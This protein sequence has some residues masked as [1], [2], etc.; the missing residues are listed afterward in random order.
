MLPLIGTL[1]TSDEAFLRTDLRDD[2]ERNVSRGSR[3]VLMKPLSEA[4]DGNDSEMEGEMEGELLNIIEKYPEPD[5]IDA[6][7]SFL[8]DQV[9]LKVLGQRKGRFNARAH[10]KAGGFSDAT[11]ME[12]LRKLKGN[13]E[14]FRKCKT[15]AK[16]IDII[17]SIGSFTKGTLRSNHVAMQL[18]HVVEKW[19][20]VSDL[21]MKSPALEKGEL[22][23]GTQRWK[24]FDTNVSLIVNELLD[25]E[26]VD[27][28]SSMKDELRVLGFFGEEARV[29]EVPRFVTRFAAELGKSFFTYLPKEFRMPPKK[30]PFG[31]TPAL[32]PIDKKERRELEWWLHKA[33]RL[34]RELSNSSQLYTKESRF[35]LSHASDANKA[36]AI[37]NRLLIGLLSRPS[38]RRVTSLFLQ[39]NKHA[40]Q[41]LKHNGPLSS[42]DAARYERIFSIGY[43]LLYLDVW[44][45]N[46]QEF[47]TPNKTQAKLPKAP[48]RKPSTGKARQS[49]GKRK[50]S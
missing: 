22:L 19:R 17:D 10:N 27:L 6:F 30:A 13:G 23:L 25:V 33:E 41:F 11:W 36:M 15:L 39:S 43:L 47:L 4:F 37:L 26:L 7:L 20:N 14:Q 31:S 18:P 16:A 32:R 8:Q 21:H 50:R 29:C 38:Y 1:G 28:P 5:A 40:K 48:K 24:A 45:R 12:A 46:S 9:T 35:E 49:V 2:D 42:S 3:H 34:R 44:R